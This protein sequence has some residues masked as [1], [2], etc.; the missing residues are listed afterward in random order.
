MI[1]TLRPLT[2]NIIQDYAYYLKHKSTDQGANN[3]FARF[4]KV[5]RQAVKDK[6]LLQSPAIDI[7][8]VREENFKMEIST[9]EKIQKLANTEISNNEVKRTFLFSCFI[10]LR[11]VDIKDPQMGVYKFRKQITQ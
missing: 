6:L 2:E 4:K 3:Y 8:I 10:G 11:W 7:T 1:T 5:L 9:I